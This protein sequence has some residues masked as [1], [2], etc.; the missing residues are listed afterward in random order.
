MAFLIV[1]RC[2]FY[3]CHRGW[4]CHWFLFHTELLIKRLCLMRPVAIH[5]KEFEDITMQSKYRKTWLNW[6]VK[7]AHSTDYY[8]ILSLAW[9]THF[10]SI[11][12]LISQNINAIL[13]VEKCTKLFLK[14]A[15]KI[16]NRRGS[17][18]KTISVLEFNN[19]IVDKLI[20]SLIKIFPTRPK[21]SIVFC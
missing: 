20:F 8:E 11:H 15:E 7:W 12:I 9:A 2:G 13:I 21:N 3:V 16:R 18:Q 10:C 5:V 14:S 6:C 1:E 4:N 17:V 19:K